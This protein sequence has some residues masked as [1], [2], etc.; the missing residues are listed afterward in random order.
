MNGKHATPPPCCK[1][2]ILSNCAPEPLSPDCTIV[3][4]SATL[5]RENIIRAIAKT[6]IILV[7]V[8]MMYLDLN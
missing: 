4:S 7:N 1:I 3:P 2:S 5:G 8:F 6:G